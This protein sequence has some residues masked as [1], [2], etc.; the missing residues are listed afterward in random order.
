MRF[1]KAGHIQTRGSFWCVAR[2][3]LSTL[4]RAFCFLI[5]SSQVI[6]W[7][8][9]SPSG[10]FLKL[11]MRPTLRGCSLST[12]SVTSPTAAETNTSPL[13][14]EDG[15]RRCLIY[16]IPDLL[17]YPAALKMQK[18]LQRERI[19]HKVAHK[20]GFLTSLQS[21]MRQNRN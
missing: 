2:R 15:Q 14:E 11:R 6:S 19:D 4:L 5:A 13:F 3:M 16:N 17:D 9:L 10:D 12:Q 20:V 21:P 8:T 1:A 18:G 7:G